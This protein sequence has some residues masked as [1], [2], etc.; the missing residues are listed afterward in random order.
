MSSPFL[1]AV[2]AW[3]RRPAGLLPAARRRM[4]GAGVPLVLALG[5]MPVLTGC[6]KDQPATSVPSAG[7][8]SAS[9]TP[10]PAVPPGTQPVSPP[11]PQLPIPSPPAAAPISCTETVPFERAP[12]ASTSFPGTITTTKSAAVA[13]TFD[14][15]P[16]PGTT[17]RVLDLLRQCGVKATFCVNGI[18]VAQ[19]AV[20]IRRIHAEGHSFCNHT[21]RHITQLGTYG[22]EGIRIDLAQTNDAIRAIVPG[23]Q[24]GYFRA[25]GGKWTADYVTVAR[26]LGMTPLHWDV[27][28]SDWDSSTYG[29]G[30]PMINHIVNEV[31]NHVKPGSVILAH[32]FQKPDTV[33]AFTT[34][35]PWLKARVELVALPPA[36]LSPA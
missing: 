28:T 17:P 29:K 22:P 35:L 16:D 15:G 12:A 32:D 1:A 36:G 24:I 7:A 34:L 23:A 4:L 6:G 25:P 3:R 30:Q 14:D 8:P 2:F 27:D 33:A 20:I 21:W 26:E 13:L 9:E 18:K 31:Q 5:L 19:N 10:S 11:P